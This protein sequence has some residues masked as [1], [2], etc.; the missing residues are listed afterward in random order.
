M[1]HTRLFGVALLGLAVALVTGCG[2]SEPK[3]HAASGTVKYKGQP[4]PNGSVTFIPDGGDAIMGAAPIK[5]GKY[6][7]PAATGLRAGKYKVAVSYPDPKGTRAE[8]EAPGASS[9]AKEL[10]PAKYNEQ[11]E[12][13]AEVT[14]GGTNVFDFD[15]K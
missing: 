8:A 2:S 1:H 6:E 11:T 13:K 7:F 15:L 10:I 4:I 12:L 5:D 3:R 14:A 9:D